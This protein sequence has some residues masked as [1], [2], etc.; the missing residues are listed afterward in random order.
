[1]SND[2]GSL[3]MSM[4]KAFDAVNLNYFIVEVKCDT[5]GN[6]TDL[7]Y[8]EISPATQRL[9]GKSKQDIMGKTR[10]E[11][12][13]KVVDEFPTK[14][15]EV[16][17]TGD[18]IHFQS[19]GAGLKKYYDVYAWKVADNEVAAIANDI[20]QLRKTEQTLK[21]SEARYHALFQNSNDA[22]LVTSPIGEVFD[23]NPSAERM[24]GMSVAELRK[25]GRANLMVQ[26]EKALQ[27]LKRAQ[28]TRS[29][30]G[31]FTYKRKDGS[32]FEGEATYSLFSDGDG[33]SK[34]SITIRDVTERKKAEEAI[35]ESE[36]F[37]RVLFENTDDGFVIL[38]PKFDYNGNLND[39]WIVKINPAYES[40]TGFHNAVGKSLSEFVPELE[41]FWI[42]IYLNLQKSGKS[43]H[44]DYYNK[45]TNKWFDT[46]AFPY[47]E[48]QVGILFRDI[49]TQ[50]I[51]EYALSESE[52]RLKV[53]LENAPA[54]VFVANP[55]GQY[56]YVN[57]T[58]S[59]LLGFSREELLGM[60]IP[61]ILSKENFEVGLEQF[62]LLIKTG[63]SH[64][65][66]R[67]K[68]K[69]GSEVYVI[70]TGAKLPDGNLI[71]NCEDITDRK[72]L[73]KQLQ[74][75]ERLAGI[76]ATAGMVGHDI[77]NPLQAMVS[78]LYLMKDEILSGCQHKA[79]L[80]ESIDSLD[81]NISYVNKIVSDLQDYARQLKPDYSESDISRVIAKVFENLRVPKSIK[82]SIN[83]KDL[84]KVQTDPMLLQRAL[85]N[86][87]V[88]AI[89]AMPTGG[90]LDILG[91]SQSGKAVISV[92][93]TGVG[94]SDEV[95]PKLFTP[96]M[97]TKAKG[98]GFGLAVSK[99]LIE[100]LNGAISFESKLGEGTKFTV[101]LPLAQ[102]K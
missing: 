85:S 51:A 91:F 3:Y 64:K 88:N 76:G 10:T 42:D 32:A 22:I 54:A 93:D 79:D 8:R 14:L 43:F 81:E 48:N 23:A 6:P 29:G 59:R 18:P 11:L 19:Y 78:D 37:Y 34:A 24:F 57:S 4:I 44:T 33:S 58:A 97:T 90:N 20:T 21:A 87:V 12:L 83:L 84:E 72:N 65:E 16:V 82:L 89:Q 27:T 73:E 60:T 95:K 40:Q 36:K 15:Y 100:A 61:Q 2:F 52:E 92:S 17:K 9:I 53:I 94:I 102:A 98:Q 86:L 96:M 50:K 71:A 70:L 75:K 39:F 28:L 41:Q 66:I 26:N 74:E 80:I 77:R 49:T 35:K 62:N 31:E 7:I 56:L 38:K 46:Y 13:G 47:I 69:D 45:F 68:R 63:S 101:E 25:A 67:L 30:K 1:M 99:R 55:Q 5:V